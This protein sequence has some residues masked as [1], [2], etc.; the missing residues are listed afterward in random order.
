MTFRVAAQLRQLQYH[1]DGASLGAIYDYLCELR[2]EF[3]SC[4]GVSKMER[5]QQIGESTPR[6]G[7]LELVRR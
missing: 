2:G 3:R 1:Q 7:K 4:L 6:V 5:W